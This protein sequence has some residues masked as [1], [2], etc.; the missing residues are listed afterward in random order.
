MRNASRFLAILGVAAVVIAVSTPA[1]AVCSPPKAATTFTSD[2][3]N[4]VYIDLGPG[5]Q[6]SAVV[7]QYYDL[8]GANS[9]TYGP[10]T[11]L[12]QDVSGKLSMSANLGAEGTI[13]CPAG[14][15][16]VRVQTSTGA[17]TRF[18]TMVAN[19]GVRNPNGAEFDFTFGKAPGTSFTGSIV[20]RPRVT[21]SA[22]AGSNVNL[23]V[24]LDS[25]SDGNAGGDSSSAVTGYDI[26]RA[27]GTDPGRD[28]A[29][30]TIVQTVTAPNG[31]AVP[32]VPLV[33]D[34]SNPAVDQ[35]FATR[36]IFGTSKGDMVSAS[37]RVNCN[38][39]LAE[40]RFNVVP[41]KPVGPKKNAGRE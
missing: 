34:C 14:K 17:G 18:V 41:K 33:A 28:P 12:F 19:E 26:V 2:I 25:A 30:W 23:Q 39:N 29:G 21:S 4:Y 3:L 27:S 40:P 1:M 16:I 6:P 10:S 20:P 35:F 32:A 13:G 24:A 9:G 36:A 7:G 8:A 5:V 37:T 15:L 11:W 31:S 38:P 22:R